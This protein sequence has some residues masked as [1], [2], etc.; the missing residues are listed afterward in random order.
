MP[1]PMEISCPDPRF[2]PNG[3]VMIN[4]YE[5]VRVINVQDE[6]TPEHQ[7]IDFCRSI[8]RECDEVMFIEFRVERD[9]GDYQTGSF[10]RRQLPQEPE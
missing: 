8:R 2:D 5:F 10:G 4:G 7:L 9:D 3:P 6:R 1:K